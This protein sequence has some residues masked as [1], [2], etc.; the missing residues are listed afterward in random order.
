MMNQ[1]R[2]K[3][4]KVIRKVRHKF[5][6]LICRIYPRPKVLNHKKVNELITFSR[7]N[8]FQFNYFLKLKSG[9][10]INH[11]RNQIVLFDILKNNIFRNKSKIKFSEYACLDG[12]L[13]W[14]LSMFFENITAVD[15]NKNNIEKIRLVNKIFKTSI[16][17]LNIDITNIKTR[18]NIITL[19]GCTYQLK[20]TMLVTNKQMPDC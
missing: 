19:L 4:I 8:V 1:K 20:K 12:Y 7:Y 15:I 5:I 16:K 10:E 13:S 6:D 18:F 2:N 11:I 9:F 3:I 17:T 14:K